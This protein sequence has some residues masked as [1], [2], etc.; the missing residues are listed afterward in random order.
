MIVIVGG[1]A[2][3]LAAAR[4]LLARR[5]DVCVL[6]ARV[7]C[8][9]E[10]STHNSGVIHAGLYYPAGSL[11]ARLCVEGR[12]RL[13]QFCQARNVPHLRCGKLIV[14]PVST[15]L[16][17][18]DE[19]ALD[20]VQKTAAAAGARLMPVDAGFIAA[21]EPHI[22]ASRG[23]WSPD[24]GW[25]E[26]DAYIAALEADV[27]RQDGVVLT[28]T[29]LVGVETSPAGLVAVTPREQ[30]EASL[31]VNAGGLYA[32][33]VSAM[34]GGERFRIYP[35]RGEYAEL[36][37]RARGLVNGLVYPVPDPSGHGLG[38]HLTR[39]LEGAVWIGPTIQY[40]NDKADYEANR[41]P[42]A[43]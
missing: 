9:L 19:A 30:I 3:G 32:D 5:H 43:S 40:Q 34:A 21:R 10:G 23:L 36:A 39:T 4:A 33:D 18:S 1:G 22:A 24:T 13:Y 25:V 37:P 29:P 27:R 17:A 35:C 26:A 7:K 6:E 41:L 42:L 14:A 11:K 12:D 16:A 2:V 8:G 31:L 38:V 28:G 20:Q 15:R